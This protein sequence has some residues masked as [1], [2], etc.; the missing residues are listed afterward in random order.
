MAEQ[1]A[2]N[3]KAIFWTALTVMAALN[4]ALSIRIGVK[5]FG[6]SSPFNAAPFSLCLLLLCAAQMIRQRSWGWPHEADGGGQENVVL[7]LMPTT[8]VWLFMGLLVLV[9]RFFIIVWD[10]R[11]AA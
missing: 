5:A 1:R 8:G 10:P 3:P 4:V 6:F 11:G 9:L 2:S 7:E